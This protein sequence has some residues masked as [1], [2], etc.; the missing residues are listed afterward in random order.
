MECSS[1]STFFLATGGDMLADRAYLSLDTNM[2][3]PQFIGDW[4]KR[5]D[6]AAS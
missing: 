5:R 4:N 6:V 1:S 2:M 3:I